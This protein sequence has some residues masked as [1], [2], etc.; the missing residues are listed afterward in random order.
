VAPF[1]LQI[2]IIF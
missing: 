1:Y 2:P